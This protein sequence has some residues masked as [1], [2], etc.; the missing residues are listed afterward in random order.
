MLDSAGR[1]KAFREREAVGSAARVAMLG[2][3]Y[4]ATVEAEIDL[5]LNRLGPLNADLAIEWPTHAPDLQHK[6][7][8]GQDVY[9]QLRVIKH[10]KTR[11]KGGWVMRST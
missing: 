6:R 3:G 4:T 9:H 7:H 2:R 5:R 11:L 10:E 1:F 8:P